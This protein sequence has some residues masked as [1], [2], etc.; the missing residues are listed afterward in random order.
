MEKTISAEEAQSLRWGI[1]LGGLLV[2][3][4]MLFFWYEAKSEFP[5]PFNLG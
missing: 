1:A 2:G 4:L 5:P 3:G